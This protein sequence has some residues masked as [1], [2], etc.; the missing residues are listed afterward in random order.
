MKNRLMIFWSLESG[1]KSNLFKYGKNSQ[2]NQS[3]PGTKK[4]ITATS[5]IPGN[6]FSYCCTE[7][8]STR[9]RNSA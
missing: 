6:I 7:S 3:L 5:I 1:F 4:N 2:E 9:F 8:Q